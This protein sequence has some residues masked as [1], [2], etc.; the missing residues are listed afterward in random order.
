ML[1]HFI[2]AFVGK[3]L[4]CSSQ[5]YPGGSLYTFAAFSPWDLGILCYST[6]SPPLPPFLSFKEVTNIENIQSLIPISSFTNKSLEFVTPFHPN[7]KKD[8]HT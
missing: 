4:P 5:Q 6:H 3:S 2:V 1:L 8:E 7:R